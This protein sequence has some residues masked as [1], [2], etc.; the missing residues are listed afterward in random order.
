MP[1]CYSI[2]NVYGSIFCIDGPI[3]ALDYGRVFVLKLSSHHEKEHAGEQPKRR[4]FHRVFAIVLCLGLLLSGVAGSTWAMNETPYALTPKYVNQ[5]SFL[6]SNGNKMTGNRLEILLPALPDRDELL[7]QLEDLLPKQLRAWGFLNAAFLETELVNAGMEIEHPKPGEEKEPTVDASGK[8][9]DAGRTVWGHI[10]LEWN[11][12]LPQTIAYDQEYRFVAATVANPGYELIVNSNDPT[13]DPAKNDSKKDPELLN[14]VVV[15]RDPQLEELHTVPSIEPENVRVNLF[16]YWVESHGEYPEAPQGDILWKSDSHFRPAKAEEPDGELV[17]S[18]VYFSTVGDWNQGINAGHLLLFGDSPIHAGLWNKGAGENTLYGKQYAGMEEIVLPNL[19]AGGYP[20]INTAAARNILTKKQP[21]EAGYRDYTLIRD[22]KLAGDHVGG[23][24]NTDYAGEAIQNFSET[25]LGLW[26]KSID[27]GVESL[28][29]LFDPTVDHPCKK[30]Y[31]NIQGLFQM[32]N[33]G[34]YYYNMRENFAEFREAPADTYTYTNTGYS[35]GRFVLYDAPATT[36]TDGD[37]SIGNFFPFNKG[38][39]VF[40]GLD[41]NGRLTSSVSCAR[42]AMNH[43]LGMTVDINF[44]QP[45]NGEINAGAQGAQDMT[46][47]FAGDDDVWVYIDDVLVLDM[48]GVHSEI[49]GTINFATGDVYIGRAFQTKGIPEHPEDPQNM[50]THTTL[51]ELFRKA[52]AEDTV[53]WEGDTFANN[54][55]HHLRMFYL[56]RGNYDSSI[57]LRFNLQP[58]LYQT[59]RKINQDGDPIEGIEFHLYAAEK[60]GGQLYTDWRF[61]GFPDHR[62]G[63]YGSICRPGPRGAPHSL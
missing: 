27:T 58:Q 62:G 39:E 37:Q 42:N 4:R 61:P 34:Y 14:M 15:L 12:D 28:D 5:W 40:D 43:H 59:I 17:D 2:G 23:E 6:D 18:P 8:E 30:S 21:G 60:N 22:Y 48:G 47:E 45:V 10:R 7:A 25:L 53:D 33:A 29:Y 16:D 49:Y 11:L 38:A 3:Q 46:F 63:R 44:L 51:R 50:V 52:G 19:D 36:R 35:D 13:A 41:E 55:D 9:W 32:D 1:F 20:V 54:S 57:A 56:E 24:Y 26:G 31:Q